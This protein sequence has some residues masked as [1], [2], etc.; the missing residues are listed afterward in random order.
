MAVVQEVGAQRVGIRLLKSNALHMMFLKPLYPLRQYAGAPM[1]LDAH[2][3]L[4][5]A[6]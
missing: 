2:P 3:D 4:P 5:P 6:L 1:K